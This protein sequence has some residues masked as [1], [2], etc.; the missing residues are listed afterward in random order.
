M[1]H[2]QRTLGNRAVAQRQPAPSPSP[3]PSPARQPAPP[4]PQAADPLL[5]DRAV[6][7]QRP[8]LDPRMT[9]DD[10]VRQLTAKVTGGQLASFQVRG[11]PA[12][13]PSEIFLLAEIFATARR[14]NWGTEADF[15]AAIGWP[16]KA[17]DP[18]PLGQI[19]LR[20]DKQG[21]AVA[22]LVGRGA[23]PAPAQLTFA[24]GKSKLAA[25]FGF[26]SVDG[27]ADNPTS[28]A[29][30][31]DVLGALELLKRRAPQDVNALRG[32][33]L[34][35]VPTLG[36]SAAG[37]YSWSEGWLKLANGAFNANA[38]Q[39]F[40]GG[41]SSPS[42]P[43]SFQTVLHEVGHAVEAE[44]LRSARQG[45]DSAQAGLDA[46]RQRIQDDSKTFVADRAAAQKKGTAK[47]NKFYKDRGESYKRLEQAETD[48]RT[49]VSEEEGK[50]N[51]TRVAAA[52]VQTLKD[53]A[54]AASATAAGSLA[55]A[56]TAVQALRPDE[57]QS[58]AAWL[59]AVETA[60]AAIAAFPADSQS[61][62][63][64]IDDIE[65][66]VQQ[67]VTA[68]DQAR[69]Q[70]RSQAAAH[71]ALPLLDRAVRDQDAWFQA[72]RVYA[73]ARIRTRRLQK[74]IDLVNANNIKRFTQYSVDKWLL[75]PE[76][77]YAEAYSL[78]LVDPDFVKTNYLAV[79][80]FFESG[81]YRR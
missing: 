74:F 51:D 35:R 41:P 42:V 77:F 32:V 53:G 27:W 26:S 25:D 5:Y 29:E 24:D 72:E 9:K 8:L 40:G 3:S 43:S 70:L 6:R 67:K 52:T 30:I 33:K 21:A 55:P 79:F 65:Q 63:A 44:N 73:H 38:D 60:A 16:A 80:N 10:I 54:A 46:A 66:A 69:A 23:V 15:L 19:T 31:S 61:G 59:Q 68:R 14:S 47:L 50:V 7:R 76:E 20:I 49:R 62:R 17:G 36:G 12:G 58:S 1:L 22:E 71:R 48:A 75:K 78:W 39:F 28:A 11:V 2:L 64:T 37:E 81:D 4:P 34:I 18:A 56:K 13:S 57:V 45:L